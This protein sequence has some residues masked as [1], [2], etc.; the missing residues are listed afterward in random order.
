MGVVMV[1]VEVLARLLAGAGEEGGEDEEMRAEGRLEDVRLSREARGVM[2]ILED[3]VVEVGTR[4]Q[5]LSF[6]S[7][8]CF[9]VTCGKQRQSTR[10]TFMDFVFCLAEQRL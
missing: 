8:R 10:K 1:D 2:G 5:S 7:G 3:I 4:R 6:E 9:S